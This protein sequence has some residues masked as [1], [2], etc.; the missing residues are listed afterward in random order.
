MKRR[1]PMIAMCSS[2]MMLA[3]TIA[4]SIA[5]SPAWAQG[6]P[7]RP[8]LQD[9][10]KDLDEL[11]EKTVQVPTLAAAV[12]ELSAR[13][14]V[15]ERQLAEREQ[16]QTAIPDAITRID[17]LDERVKKLA[18]DIDALRTALAGVEQ[19]W[20]PE[21]SGGG[22]VTYN[23][24]FAWK[25]AD[26]DYSLKLNAWLFM[27]Q[28]TR[29]SGGDIEEAT[30][31]IREARVGAS[32]RLGTQNL[33]Y[34]LLLSGLRDSALLEFYLD[35][36]IRDE[37]VI[38]AGQYKT[39]FTRAFTTSSTLSD[40]H[41]LARAVDGYRYDRDIQ[42][43]LHGHLAGK[44]FGYHLAVGNGAGPNARNDN[45]DVDATLRVD[46]VV[47]GERFAYSYG[48]LKRTATPT[49]MVGAG[50]VHDLVAMPDQV[51]G[52]DGAIDTD[53]D[54]NG[55]RDNVR[56]F[57]ASV[58][59]IFRFRGWEAAVEGVL[60]NEAFGSIL[61]DPDN[62][63]L[64]AAVGER[65]RRLYLGVN[66]QVSR[67]LPHD[68]L[69]AARAGYSRQ[70]FLGLSGRASAIPESDHLLELDALVQL[71]NDVGYRFVGLMYS[72]NRHDDDSVADDH[73]LFL[74][75]QLRL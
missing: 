65:G 27:R 45:L 59:A 47:L 70:P 1:I 62:A 75:A 11:R 64:L 16:G 63:G 10:Q 8:S 26:G 53:V 73:R 4:P 52:V 2:A 55:T 13:L 49:L 44:R 71:Y 5:P 7:A 38:R 34:K 42:V 67:I 72:Y 28:Q 17:G 25:T 40:F 35:Y 54:G 56:V 20:A 32:G 19:P 3:A 68:I 6:T 23:N 29:I 66:G 58:D 9:L 31:R 36:A 46:A 21:S 51:D 48:D 69:V 61:R 22:G 43:G 12:E 57:S 74:Q 50:V 60:R 14:A 39:Q 37:L 24:G 30:F 18:N 33:D 15:L 41:E